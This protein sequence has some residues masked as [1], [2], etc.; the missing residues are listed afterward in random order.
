VRSKDLRW[1]LQSGTSTT[2]TNINLAVSNGTTSIADLGALEYFDGTNWMPA[3]GGQAVMAAGQASI[4]VR[5][6]TV[7]D[8]IV[9]ST[10]QFS[11][12]ASVN[13][14]TQTSPG[15]IID[16]DV[17]PTVS[18]ASG[19][20]A[21]EPATNGSFILSRTG[22]T[23]EALTVNLGVATGTAT[24]GTDYTAIATTATF[25]VG[26]STATVNVNTIDDAIIEATETII[27]SLLAGSGYILGTVTQASIDL[28]SDDV[29]AAVP[30]NVVTPGTTGK[31]TI[32]GGTANDL[33]Q[34]GGGID[35]LRGNTGDDVIYAGTLLN[36]NSSGNA[37]MYGDGGNDTIYGGSVGINKLA[38]T[39]DTL[40]GLGEQDVLYGGS[41]TGST[42][43]VDTFVLGNI[44]S[45][46][47]LG[48]N[49]YAIINNFDPL[50]D[51]IQLSGAS[52]AFS[53]RYSINNSVA[54]VSSISYID[55]ITSVPNLIA[56]VNSATPLI[57]TGSYFI[58]APGTIIL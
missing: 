18:I 58:Q 30:L 37:T 7:D 4:Q 49:D 43:S 10:E 45:C 6:N 21:A 11:L 35:I 27:L 47:Y 5:V 9:E 34:G 20:N 19:I 23:T 31:D 57:I 32:T 25:L 17:Y 40:L 53:T 38:G 26:S 39:N 44:N 1:Y 36:P 41:T 13:G 33:I 22:S 14:S 46:Y 3:T 2:A 24:S 8:T 28:T 50:K 29:V 42:S 54:G 16:N 56:K 52:T 15:T 48:T 12:A 55:P 51:K